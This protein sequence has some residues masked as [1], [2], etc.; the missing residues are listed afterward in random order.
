[1]SRRW[2]EWSF[3]C[4]I[5][6]EGGGGHD[7]RLPS[8]AH[9][10]LHNSRSLET[11]RWRTGG[12]RSPPTVSSISLPALEATSG[13]I[14]TAP[15]PICHRGHDLVLVGAARSLG[16]FGSVCHPRLRRPGW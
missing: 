13:A 10:G 11:R 9:D 15:D 7:L 16:R 5:A 2:P 3:R 4:T 6:T 8:F 14:G 12:R 1:M